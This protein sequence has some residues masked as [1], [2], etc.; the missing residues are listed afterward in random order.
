MVR[1]SGEGM[2]AVDVM[3]VEVEVEVGGSWWLEAK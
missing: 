2:G 1:E 3:K